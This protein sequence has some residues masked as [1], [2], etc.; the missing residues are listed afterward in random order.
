MGASSTYANT[1]KKKKY[2]V[3]PKTPARRP[4]FP[5][6]TAAPRTPGEVSERPRMMFRP[7]PLDLMMP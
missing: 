3:A 4:D 1:V 2:L 6:V 5:V 7:R